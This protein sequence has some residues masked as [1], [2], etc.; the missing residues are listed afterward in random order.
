MRA[1]RSA[2][3]V[4]ACQ[5]TSGGEAGGLA[6]VFHEARSIGF[7][8]IALLDLVGIEVAIGT[9]GDAPWIVHVETQRRK[10][11]QG[12]GVMRRW[13]NLRMARQGLTPMASSVLVFK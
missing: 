3:E 4:N 7:S 9:L 11:G 2:T 12:H 13:S 8:I 5:R 10:F 1:R 6:R